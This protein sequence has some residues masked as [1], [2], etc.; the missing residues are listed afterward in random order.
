VSG[1]EEGTKCGAIFG[2]GEVVE[3]AAVQAEGGGGGGGW[4]RREGRRPSEEKGERAGGR[5]H[6]LGG[7]RKE[8]RLKSLLRLKSKEVKENQ[9]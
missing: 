7:K 3:A 2:R 4:A 8:A 6:G 9:F 5:L 1:S